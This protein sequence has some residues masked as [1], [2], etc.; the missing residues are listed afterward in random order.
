[1]LESNCHRPI[2]RTDFTK[3]SAVSAAHVTSAAPTNSHDEL[4]RRQWLTELR[5]IQSDVYVCHQAIFGIPGQLTSTGHSLELEQLNLASSLA[6]CHAQLQAA[7]GIVP[8]D[9]G[10]FPTEIHV[11]FRK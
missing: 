3:A 10:S 2:S 4:L 11:A 6:H 5:D 7:F 9:V 1:M 8:L